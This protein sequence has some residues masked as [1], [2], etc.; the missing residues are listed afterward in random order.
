VAM[1]EAAVSAL[2]NEWLRT[3]A[4]KP[5]VSLPVFQFFFVAHLQQNI[6]FY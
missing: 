5:F 4:P 6:L 1:A 2:V 3:D